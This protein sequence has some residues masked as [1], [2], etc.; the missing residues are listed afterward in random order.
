MT[1]KHPLQSK[2]WGEFREKTGVKVVTGKNFLLTIHPL[3]KTNFT[4]GYLPK[5]NNIDQALLNELEII[6][7]KE[8]CIFIQIEPNIEKGEIKYNFNNLV[9]AA[10]PL[11]TKYNFILDISK[12]EEEILKNMSQKTRYNIRLAEKKGVTITKD[13]SETA[14]KDYLRLTK[15][16]T[17]R[18]KFYSHTQKYHQLM[19]DTLKTSKAI[20]KDELSAHLF[21]AKYNNETLAA[22]ILF[23]LGDTLYYPYGSSSSKHREVMAS[24]LLMWEAIKFGKSLGLKNF[25]M[26]GALGTNP[27]PKD[28][29]FGFHRFKQG[30]NPRAVEYVGSFD[31]II[32]N[33]MYFIYK[34]ADKIRWALLRFK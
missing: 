2:K 29:W 27:N 16:T 1:N 21:I 3:P 34:I 4:I 11:F 13:N 6:G 15:E 24:N 32:N 18:Q 28:P 10:H 8:N 5:G 33:K 19:W 17:Q 9:S 7:K 23:V 26:W 31:L 14:F 30:Y 12:S 22:W 25:D 20:N